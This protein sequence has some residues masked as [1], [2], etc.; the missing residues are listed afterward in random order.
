[1]PRGHASHIMF[2]VG[3]DRSLS[4]KRKNEL[5][6]PK[7]PPPAN[8]GSLKQGRKSVDRWKRTK[9]S[10]PTI[11]IAV[12]LTRNK[13]SMIDDD[14]P[15]CNENHCHTLYNRLLLASREEEEEEKRKNENQPPAADGSYRGTR[16]GSNDPFLVPTI[17]NKKLITTTFNPYK[18]TLS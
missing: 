13:R 17:T 5:S 18:R 8:L 7:S 15:G 2:R 9:V 6:P 11:S 1:M 16:Q 10:G 3:P 4:Q 14:A 12:V